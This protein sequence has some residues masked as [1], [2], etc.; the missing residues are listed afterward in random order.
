VL[1]AHVQHLASFAGAG[2][3]PEPRS[4]PGG[5]GDLA[6][7]RSL[8]T[9]P[10]S[11]SKKLG[12]GEPLGCNPALEPDGEV[13]FYCVTVPLGPPTPVH[14]IIRHHVADCG[15]D[16]GDDR[17]ERQITGPVHPLALGVHMR[18]HRQP[19]RHEL[20]QELPLLGHRFPR[21]IRPVAEDCPELLR[22]IGSRRAEGVGLSEPVEGQPQGAA[23]PFGR[24]EL[25]FERFRRRAAL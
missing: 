25:L 22:E 2:R 9:E 17:R 8:P 21:D 5:R 3:L 19:V 23:F 14:W 7:V 15:R 18:R 4:E 13:G 20:P 6:R 24:G 10:G 16:A 12:R 1:V 11:P